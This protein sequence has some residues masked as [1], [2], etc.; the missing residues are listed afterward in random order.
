MTTA[1]TSF[2]SAHRLLTATAST[3]GALA[4]ALTMTG[5]SAPADPERECVPAALPQAAQALI[6]IVGTHAGTPAPNVPGTA[7][8]LLQ[9]T[10]AAGNPVRVI[11]LDGTP[12]LL[13]LPAV[14]PV[15]RNTCDGFA[16]TLA[17]ATNSVIDAVKAAAADSDGNDLYSALDLAGKT[18]HASG[19]NNATILVIDSGLAERPRS[20]INFAQENMTQADPEQVSTFALASQPLDLSGLTVDFQGLGQTAPPQLPLS[21]AEQIVVGDTWQNI[22]TKANAA[23]VRITPVP[24]TGPGPDTQYVTLLTPVAAVDVFEPPTQDAPTTFTLGEADVHFAYNEADLTDPATTQ[25]RLAPVVAWLAADP[26]HHVTLYGRTDSSGSRDYNI[27]LSTRRAETVKATI[28]RANPDINPEQID[29][30]GQGYDFE[31]FIPDTRPDG[32]LDP[33][34]SAKNRHVLILATTT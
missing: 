15:S 29:T 8:P 22:A 30:I 31:G 23:Q 34:K 5:C 11:A 25:K 12:A 3:A 32:S 10:L 2:S 20:P 16:T 18:A 4:L 33:A 24:R 1:T 28:L 26:A 27:D 6:M 21:P 9:A 13:E 7:A 14:R 19:W 17:G